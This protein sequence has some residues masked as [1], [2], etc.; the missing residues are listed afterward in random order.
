M[1]KQQ[2]HISVW[3]RQWPYL[4][5]GGLS[6]RLKAQAMPCQHSKA[7][8]REIDFLRCQS[9]Q[10]GT[11]NSPTLKTNEQRL[12]VGESYLICH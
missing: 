12:K 3:P 10:R 4:L 5:L 11:T 7:G 9:T 8:P 2:L 1:S 6:L